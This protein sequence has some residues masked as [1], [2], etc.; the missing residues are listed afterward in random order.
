M[1]TT[2]LSKEIKDFLNQEEVKQEIK[3]N[4]W[5]EF[6][7]LVTDS[8][9]GSDYFGSMYEVFRKNGINIL[10]Y[11]DFVPSYYYSSTELTSIT[12]P[13]NILV[14]EKYSFYFSSIKNVLLPPK[15]KYIKASCFQYNINI[16]SI[17]IPDA[18]EEIGDF[19]FWGCEYLRNIKL[20][21]NIRVL[22][23]QIFFYTRIKTLSISSS[24]EKIHPD[25]FKNSN[26]TTIYYK[27][28][29]EQWRKVY[30]GYSPDIIVKFT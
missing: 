23:N 12:I 11:T 25:A 1:K 19:S 17:N 29:V 4:N 3:D 8:L 27:G 22:G 28:T 21:E 2:E 26:I 9:L 10:K 6:N 16:E 5:K 30:T 24:I 14:L 13:T 7:N 15:L 20:S 18:V